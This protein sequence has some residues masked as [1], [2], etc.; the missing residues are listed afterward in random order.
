MRLYEIWKCKY[1]QN[2]DN[3]EGRIKCKKY[4]ILY[5]IN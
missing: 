1:A 3:M 2:A 5:N 4:N